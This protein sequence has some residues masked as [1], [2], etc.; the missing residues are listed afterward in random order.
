MMVQALRWMVSGEADLALFDNA[1]AGEGF[2][3]QRRWCGGGLM[4]NSEVLVCLFLGGGVDK[5]IES[6]GGSAVEW[7]LGENKRQGLWL[8]YRA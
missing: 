6:R 8:V 4:Q 2:P 3:Y 1:I 7:S 5:K